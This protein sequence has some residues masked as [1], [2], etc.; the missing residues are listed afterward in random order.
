MLVL[1]AHGDFGIAAHAIHYLVLGVGVLGLVALLSPWLLAAPALDEH[2]ARVAALRTALAQPSLAADNQPATF[3][4]DQVAS[5]D[6]WLPTRQSGQ[7]TC[8]SPS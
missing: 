2:E 8:A 1:H 5:H 6:S 3:D 4:P 7:C